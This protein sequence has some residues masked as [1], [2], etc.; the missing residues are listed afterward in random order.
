MYEKT[1][2]LI[3]R[4]ELNGHSGNETQTAFPTWDDFML[5]LKLAEM[6]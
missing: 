1:A 6:D 4:F 2:Y 3:K 5:A